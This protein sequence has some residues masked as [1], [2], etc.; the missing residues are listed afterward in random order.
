[1]ISASVEPAQEKKQLVISSHNL[2]LC[3]FA[4][5]LVGITAYFAVTGFSY[6]VTP[7]PERPFHAAHQ[8]LRP[9][10]V[11]G[12]RLGI[13]ALLMFFFIYLYPLRKKLK[14][15]RFMGSTKHIL[16]YHIILGL[17]A[18]IWV[19]MH[20][21]FKFRGIAG[22]AFWIMLCVV[23]SGIVGRYLY[24]QIP[25]SRKDSE[26]TLVELE[27]LRMEA[28]LQLENFEMES[29]PDGSPL[30]APIDRERVRRMSLFSAAWHMILLDLR[31]PFHI[32]ALRRQNLSAVERL[33][34]LGGFLAS[35][36]ADLE[37][38]MQVARKQS[39]LS[40]K[41]V[42]LDRASQMFQLWHVVHRP[43]SYGF[44][45]LAVLHITLVWAM[46]FL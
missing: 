11:I 44:V 23:I 35:S 32:A 3:L 45:F 27:H 30:F 24:S 9:G 18:P 20:S 25:R 21:A 8:R 10:G 12:I 29:G 33:T 13:S 4:L 39:W 22:V 26:F 1:M 7:V 17:C 41:I 40:A 34:T 37:R 6:Y 15:L 46:G 14:F 43:F 31:R 16:D 42:F 38:V 36:H 2:R 5:A 28:A 19:A